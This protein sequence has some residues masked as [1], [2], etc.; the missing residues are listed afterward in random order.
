VP[1]QAPQQ[2]AAHGGGG[3]RAHGHA[4]RGACPAAPAAPP[5]LQTREAEGAEGEE[6]QGEGCPVPAH[7][8]GVYGLFC[9]LHFK[10][11]SLGCVFLG[12]CCVGERLGQCFNNRVRQKQRDSV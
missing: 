1:T 5:C 12:L 11:I 7:A 8:C 6:G 4:F 10:R 2:P 3:A 9:A